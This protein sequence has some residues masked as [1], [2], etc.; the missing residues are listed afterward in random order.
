MA[1]NAHVYL[2][3]ATRVPANC[4]AD[5]LGIAARIATE[6]DARDVGCSACPGVALAGIAGGVSV[7]GCHRAFVASAPTV[8]KARILPDVGGLHGRRPS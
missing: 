1:H 2:A 5:P 7:I 6:V 3:E 8:S 4:A